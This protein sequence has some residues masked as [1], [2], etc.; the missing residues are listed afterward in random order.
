MLICVL[1]TGALSTEP[2]KLTFFTLQPV[3]Y[4]HLDVYKRQVSLKVGGS[5]FINSLDDISVML[6]GF[7]IGG[8]ITVK[9]D[10][11]VIFQRF[12]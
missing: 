1:S 8:V 11:F 3:S 9:K 10:F 6:A 4:T 2:R 5:I 7:I 12:L